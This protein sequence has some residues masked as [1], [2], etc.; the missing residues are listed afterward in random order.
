MGLCGVNGAVRVSRAVRSR[1]SCA[2][3]CG[4]VRAEWGRVELCGAGGP[5]MVCGTVRGGQGCEG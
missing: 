4:I 2:G 5:C 3:L 1:Q